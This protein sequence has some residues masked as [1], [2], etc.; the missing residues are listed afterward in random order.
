[1]ARLLSM[2]LLGLTGLTTLPAMAGDVAKRNYLLHC[3]GCHQADGSGSAENGIPDMRRNLGHFLRTADGRAFVVQV[4]GT[5]Q[6][7]LGH[8]EVADLLNW[9]LPAISAAEVPPGFQPFSAAEVAA[10]RGAPLPDVFATRGRIVEAVRGLGYP[11][12]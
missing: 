9:L 1:M 2:L 12:Q 3:S 7:A 4:P 10:Y 8:A 11:L 6:S 5:S